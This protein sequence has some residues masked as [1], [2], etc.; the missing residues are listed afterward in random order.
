M[1]TIFRSH[2]DG[3]RKAA[4]VPERIKLIVPVGWSNQKAKIVWQALAVVQPCEEI[5]VDKMIVV[6]QGIPGRLRA[7]YILPVRF[8]F[9]ISIFEKKVISTN[10]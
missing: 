6:V 3:P 10:L 5:M 7:V 4:D 9:R 1:I 2:S 8:I